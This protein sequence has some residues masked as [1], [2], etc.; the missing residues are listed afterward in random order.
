MIQARHHALVGGFLSYMFDALEIV[1]LAIALPAIMAETGMSRADAGLLVTATLLGIGVSSVTVGWISDKFGR[2]PALLSSLALFGICTCIMAL[3][4][5]WEQMMALRFAA[6]LGLGGVWSIVSAYIAETWPKEHQARATSLVLSSFPLGSGVAAILAALILPEHGWRML[7]LICGGSTFISI[8][9]VYFF[10]PES[11]QWLAERDIDMGR[12][13]LA[14]PFEIFKGSLFYQT[15]F[16][17]VSASFS[18]LAYWGVT[19]WLPTYLTSERGFDLKSMAMYLVILNAATFLGYLIFGFFADRYGKRLMVV[20]SL[21]ATAGVLP[22]F[23]FA[24][25]R[26]TL[27]VLGMTYAFFL[28]FPG[29]YGSYFSSLYPTRLRTTGA[30]FCFNVGRGVSALAPFALGSL[31]NQMGFSLALCL[32]AV[33]YGASALFAACLSQKNHGKLCS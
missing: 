20:L 29:L 15:I 7:F 27:M 21:L 18:L 23:A 9:Y 3:L 32:C 28:V 30:G 12:E 25:D 14:G 31:S 26:S 5:S 22:F 24:Q 17:T 2:R 10:L 8:A 4:N 16:A 6:G 13:V 33:F 1:I 11:P 19:S